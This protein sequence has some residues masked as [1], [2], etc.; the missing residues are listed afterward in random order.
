MTNIKLLKTD[1]SYNN[2]YYIF[3]VLAIL[4]FFAFYKTYF[5]SI[6][7]F[8][9]TKFVI[10]CHAITVTLWLFVLIIQPILIVQK[11]VAQ[12]KFLGRLTYYLFPFVIIFMLL[13]ER[14]LYQKLELEHAPHRNNLAGL[15]GTLTTILPFAL[16]YLLALK[17]KKNTGVHARYMVG[18]GLMLLSSALWRIFNRWFDVNIGDS[19]VSAIWITFFT[20]LGFLFY[21]KRKGTPIKGNPFMFIASVYFIINLLSVVVPNTSA[22][23]TFS[24]WVVTHIF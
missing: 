16:F 19:F 2:S 14:S 18:T 13:M 17:Y 20:I 22:W 9:S 1:K 8:S 12:H 23:Q 15:F 5:G 11:K 6:T 24:Q 4:C 3:I 21:D 7:Y 10:H